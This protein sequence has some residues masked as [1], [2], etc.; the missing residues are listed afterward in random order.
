MSGESEEETVNKKKE[1]SAQQYGGFLVVSSL[2][3]IRAKLC[4][5]WVGE[6][7]GPKL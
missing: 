5:N 7:F 6:K 3:E 4:V 1:R 2:T